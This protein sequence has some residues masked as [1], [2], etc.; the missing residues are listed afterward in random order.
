[1]AT[2]WWFLSAI[3]SHRQPHIH[4]T[5]KEHTSENK[6]QSIKWPPDCQRANSLHDANQGYTPPA[7][8]RLQPAYPR[9][10]NDIHTNTPTGL[11]STTTQPQNPSYPLY[12][13]VSSLLSEKGIPTSEIPKIPASGPKGRLLKGDVLAYLGSIAADYPASQA[14]HL[15]KISHLDLSNIKIAPP[16]PT[17]KPAEPAAAAEPTPEAQPEAEI[18]TINIAISVSL[19]QLL[20]A[21]KKLEESLGISIPIATFLDRATELANDDLPRLSSAP[22][23]ADELFDEVLGEPAITTSRGDY[24]PD[25]NAVDVET[26][27]SAPAPAQG[28]LIDF[29]AGNAPVRSADSSGIVQE[30]K[31]A[32]G[33]AANVFSLTVPI[34]E[35]KRARAF[36]ERIKVLLQVEPGRLVI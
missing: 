26:N 30:E 23:T 15:Q 16:A 25:L 10:T 11:Q 20:S 36:L 5:E 12:P 22:R 1:M 4:T 28:D 2:W 13:S 34:G 35:E 19:S 29:L 17:A 18:E 31:A 9:S 3:S 6:Q 8:V 14:A 24:V 7:D 21:Q 33:A 32:S 27:K